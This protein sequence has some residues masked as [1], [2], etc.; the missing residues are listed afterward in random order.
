MLHDKDA[1]FG[2]VRVVRVARRTIS[3]IGWVLA[4]GP[5][6]LFMALVIHAVEVRLHLGRWPIVYRD[7]PRS[8]LLSL[9]EYGVLAPTFYWSLFGVP[10]WLLGAAVLSGFRAVARGAL[11][12]QLAIIIIGILGIVLLVVADPTGYM[13]WLLD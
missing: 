6:V 13:E 1:A 12:R 5:L 11:T 8:W 2:G 7:D 9:H 10:A 4:S 3:S